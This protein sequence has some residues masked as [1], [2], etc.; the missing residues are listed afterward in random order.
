[1]LK[2]KDTIPA[3]RVGERGYQLLNDYKHA[4]SLNSIGE[5]VRQ[6]LQQSPALKAFV[7]ADDL[8]DYFDV[9]SWGGNRRGEQEAGDNG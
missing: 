9:N 6:L 2:G 7:E 1:M 3:I 4:H 5:A 8:S